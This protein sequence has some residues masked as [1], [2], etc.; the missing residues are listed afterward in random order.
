MQPGKRE[1]AGDRLD[2]GHMPMIRQHP[3]LGVGMACLL[4]ACLAGCSS[5][6]S[7]SPAPASGVL[8][9]TV[10][11]TSFAQVKHAIDALYH[12]HPG[13]GTF[14][15]QGVEYAPKTRDKVLKVCRDGSVANTAQELETE[16]VM[17]CAPLIYFFAR[18]G[19][20]ASVPEST[21]VARQLYWYAVTQNQ[22]PY[23]STQV[24][25]DLLSSWGVR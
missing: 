3:I 22:H 18:Y 16:R 2:P 4:A 10:H 23:N 24:L 12:S 8:D 9:G 25:T 20:R 11:Q 7:A 1:G 17:A 6:T 15:V 21:E 19:I 13:I 5:V 14:Q